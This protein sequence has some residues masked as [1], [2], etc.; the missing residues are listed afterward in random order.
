MKNLLTIAGSDSSGGAGI[1]AD[2]KTFAA[3]GAYGMSAI[4]AVTVQNTRGVR[5]SQD[6]RPEIISGQIEAV[7]EDIQVHGV[8]I[9]MVSRA[10][11][12]L[13]ISK[14]LEQF[15][16]V[17]VVIDPV[18]VSKSGFPLLSPD[19][20]NELI[21]RLFPLASMITPNIPEAELLTGTAITCV[22]EMHDAARKLFEL[23]PLRVLVK[24]GHLSSEATD[25]LF[26]GSSFRDFPGKKI[27]T[28]HTHGT[29]CTLSAAITTFLANGM[30]PGE[31]IARA[32]A[33]LTECI[34]H[35]PGIGKG[36]GPLNHLYPLY[37]K[38][39][40]V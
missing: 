9:G 12:I 14:T 10:E 27:E 3:L 15:P 39:G 11:T 33:Y 29:G 13:S 17:P 4:T 25:V 22:K 8:K 24:G 28:I 30:P 38:A 40:L 21:N 32:K 34:A 18:M 37:R 1:Q 23:G 16:S 5:T 26:D 19:A 31:A 20:A 6:L 2:L 7:F 36:A 35:A